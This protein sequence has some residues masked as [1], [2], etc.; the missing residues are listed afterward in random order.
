MNLEERAFDAACPGVRGNPF[1]PH[2]PT[3]RQFDL[4]SLHRRRP[5]DGVIRALY[6]GAAGGGK[7]DALLMAAGQ[8]AYLFPSYSGIIFRRTHTDLAQPGALMDRAL[9]WW[10]PRGVAWDGTNKI[11]RFP[12]GSKVALAYMSSPTDKLR[13]QSANYQDVF[14]DELTHWP[15][16]SEFDYVGLSRVRRNVVDGA[17]PLRNYAGSNPGGPG[18]NWVNDYFVADGAPWEFIPATIDDNPHI[19]R[20][21]Y[22]EGLRH[23]DPVTRARLLA[24]DWSAREPGDY[25]RVGWFGPLL[26]EDD[27][28]PPRDKV[29]V[30]WWDLAAS[31][32]KTAARTAGIRMAQLR[33]GVRV[34][35]HATAF[36]ATPGARNDR[37]V[38][39][40]KSDGPHVVVGL[41]VEGGSGGIAQVEALAGKLRAEGI[42]VSWARPRA[43]VA[44]TDKAKTWITRQPVEKGKPARAAPVSASLERGYIRRG[45]GEDDGSPEWGVDAGVGLEQQGD[46][47][48]CH[49]GAWNTDFF[50]EIE[51]FPGTP[52]QPA[53]LMDYVDAMSGAWAYLEVHGM[54]RSR[55]PRGRRQTVPAQTQDVHPD[56]RP[57][58]RER[59]AG[60]RWRL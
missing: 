25:F 4:L 9:E 24:G 3:P 26:V 56:L 11:F 14:F 12:N 59:D 31:L 39:T 34:L 51:G 32:A 33:G 36:R 35:E 50:D 21:A 60:G 49:A 47:I 6:G 5:R 20:E 42:R 54:G 22:I 17:I 38:Q 2:W 45:E 1:L 40:A 53:P 57:E 19:D 44:P 41:E 16:P 29:V 15:T 27:L 43:P 28:V 23:L 18:H 13:Y 55:P 7:S 58:P 10:K 46:G 52:E 48:R 8:S 37:I 30:R